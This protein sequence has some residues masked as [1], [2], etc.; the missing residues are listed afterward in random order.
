MAYDIKSLFIVLSLFLFSACG[1]NATSV[2]E[3][4]SS[5]EE[6]LTTEAECIQVITHAYHPETLEEKDYAT[7]CDVPKD[8]IVGKVPYIYGKMGTHKVEI[9]EYNQDSRAV[10][11]HPYLWETLPTPIVFFAT[12]WKNTDHNQYKK[13][14]EF[15]ASHGYSVIYVPDDGSYYSQRIKFD[16]IINE[17]IDKLDTS[18]IGVI[19]HSSGGGF[20]FKILEHMIAKSYG[21]NGR[22]LFAMDPYFAVNM[23][24]SNMHDLNNT[25][26]VFLQFG[27]SGNS[28]DP[29]MVLTNYSLLIGEGIDKN[30]IVLADDNDHMYPT[31]QDITKMQGML[32][33]LDAL[34][35]Y[36]FNMQSDT[37]HAVALEG[38]GKLNPY[39]NAYQK[40]LS[41]DSYQYSCT[42]A[43]TYHKGSDGKTQSTINNCGEPEIQAN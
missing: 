37:H 22:F 14:L 8:W 30:Y 1:S 25:N 19:G 35:E 5:M 21:E 6:N 7:P 13:L 34:I 40:V 38:V 4:S 26:M 31:R 11:Y 28:T 10:V 32:K 24:K 23:D 17:Y 9:S 29:R 41:I 39:L 2:V 20:T 15:I 42:Y 18:K 12:G 33:P 43:N 3:N 27:P 36:T 16:N